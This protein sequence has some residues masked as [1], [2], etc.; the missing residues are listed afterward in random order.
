MQNDNL[1]DEKTLSE[2]QIFNGK[3]INV[4]L[5]EVALPNGKKANREVVDHPGGVCIAALTDDNNLLFVKQYRYPYHEIILELPA[6][7]LESGSTPLENGIR[8][9]KE[10][11]GANG[12]GYT[13]LGKLYPSPGYVSE[14]IHLYFCRVDEFSTPN[15]D[16]DEFLEVIKIPL[17]EAVA[18]VL[19]NQIADSKTQVTILKTKLLL[20]NGTL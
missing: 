18:M 16:E 19:N 1:L 3:I 11:T 13:S 9:L 4:H 7:K 6:G 15:P 12:Y 10:E 17:E 2:N 20:E 14:I 8:E 5:D